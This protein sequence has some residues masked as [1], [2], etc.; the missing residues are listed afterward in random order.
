MNHYDLSS[1]DLRKL[2]LSQFMTL[3]SIRDFIA[4][5][6]FPAESEPAESATSALVEAKS[7]ATAHPAARPQAAAVNGA[8]VYHA[9]VSA[10]ASGLAGLDVKKK[11]IRR[12][13]RT[14][15]DTDQPLSRSGLIGR[16]DAE[17]SVLESSPTTEASSA[18][19]TEYSSANS[20]VATV[21]IPA[22]GAC[23]FGLKLERV[24]RLPGMPQSPQWQGDA[25]IIGHNPLADELISRFRAE[26]VVTHQIRA[27]NVTELD[28]ELDRIW[29]TAETPHLFITSPHD[30]SA[31]E[32][33]TASQWALR[34]DAAI[35]IPFRTCQRW[36]QRL[37]DQ[38]DMA[39]A[40]LAT[41][42]NAG[43]D[44]GFS[45]QQIAAPESG[46][47]AG[48]TKAMLI[49]SWMRGFRETPMK[50]I[51]VRPETAT[52]AA[53]DGI[54]R[55]LA[56]PSHD[57]EVVVDGEQRW[58][59]RPEYLPLNEQT[60][61]NGSPTVGRPITRGGT[62]IVSGGG[63]GI[64]ALTAMA[65]AEQ[66]ALQ[67]H[68]LGT[69]PHPAL[70]DAIRIR[71]IKDRPALRREVMHHAQQLG[72]NPIETWRDTEKAIEIDITLQE[73]KQRG[74]QAFYHSV[75]VSDAS[76][77]ADIV[78]GIRQHHGP[79]RGVIHGAGA[80][81]DARFDRKRIDKVEK[82]IRAK[83][84]GAYALADATQDDPL[85]WFVGFGSISGRFGA[86]G[87]T[88]YSLANDMLAKVIGQ[89][90]ERRPETACVTFHWHAWGDIGM[91]TKPEAKLALEMIGM[92]FMPAD[93]GLQHFL[94]ELQFGGH[95]TEVLITDRNY[96]RKFFP[97]LGESAGDSLMLPMLDPTGVKRTGR[98]SSGVKLGVNSGWTVT[99]NPSKDRF[100]V[101]HRVA[102]L[103]TLPFVVAIEMLAE[104]ATHASGKPVRHFR[105]V[106]ALHPVKF[107]DGD[108]FAVEVLPDG[109]AM[110]QWQL[111]ADLRRKDG[112]VVKAGVVR[113]RGTFNSRPEVSQ[114]TM[115][116][117][118][119]PTRQA[120]DD[121]WTIEYME[122]D[123]PIYHGETLQ[124]L[125][126]LQ[127]QDRMA[128]GVI[129]APSLVQLGGVERPADGWLVPCA[130][131]D[132]MLYASAVLAYHVAQRGSLPVRFETIDI[133]RMPE[134]GEPLQVHAEVVD[135][136]QDGATLHVDLVGLN[137]DHL[138]ALR[139]YRIHWLQ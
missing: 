11:R 113:F 15:I 108:A 70:S 56:C 128:I 34:R 37:I 118:L 60:R 16:W 134:P 7:H 124:C 82:C 71:A 132:A 130:A 2:K 36:M 78:A 94:N 25:L 8:H 39:K 12:E 21:P 122:P 26:G 44:F 133:G 54:F 42:V 117:R 18:N 85:E 55:E 76:A 123:A 114:P 31:V 125:R 120:T 112:R 63:R 24:P 87:H 119:F 121:A 20:T 67:L 96:I 129:T 22:H 126:T 49:E 72:A 86:N 89:L 81:Q 92:E 104:A 102:G 100:L 106:E 50:V 66:H 111:V 74:I 51:D 43:G 40:T 6:V 105:Q 84:D 61:A 135:H 109:E 23:R 136:D 68:L 47:M 99:L 57:E 62:W 103:P 138:M 33:E 139:H 83:V 73:C 29:Q 27:Q 38:D 116:T 14:F 5:N 48:L 17:R 52:R 32:V 59:V 90:K 1:I 101:D 4:D 88:D 93:Q 127:I 77:V 45:R 80:G 65:L 75:D 53:V 9:T 19:S 98:T 107:A 131:M 58:A 30:S 35:V 97:G 3:A 41:I 13:Q 69:A 110:T 115:P 64:T 46:A 137:N 28:A 91:A 10:D 79:I 95:R